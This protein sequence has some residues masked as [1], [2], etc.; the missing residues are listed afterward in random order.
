[1]AK[2]EVTTTQPAALVRKLGRVILD[3]VAKTITI[4]GNVLPVDAG[5]YTPIKNLIVKY[6]TRIPDYSEHETED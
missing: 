2:F 6:L 3:P 4:L 1:M 5:D